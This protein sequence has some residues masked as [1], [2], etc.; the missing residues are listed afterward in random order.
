MLREHADLLSRSG[1]NGVVGTYVDSFYRVHD[2]YRYDM[3]KKRNKEAVAASK[4]AAAAVKTA[5]SGDA[6]ATKGGVGAGAGVGNAGGGR[7]TSESPLPLS[8]TS[9]DGSVL[10]KSAEYYASQL[11]PLIACIGLLSRAPGIENMLDVLVRPLISRVD[12]ALSPIDVIIIEEL[13]NIAT[14]CASSSYKEIVELYVDIYLRQTRAADS[15]VSATVTNAFLFLASYI[16]IEHAADL[17]KRLMRLFLL[18]GQRLDDSITPKAVAYSPVVK[19]MSSL[20][21]AI[22]KLMV[23]LREHD[24]MMQQLNAAQEMARG[25]GGAN[26]DMWNELGSDDERSGGSSMYDEDEAGSDGEAE[27]RRRHVSAR[28]A[29]RGG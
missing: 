19:C 11:R 3:R 21:P 6:G 2:S 29:S 27:Q 10:E 9:V 24:E 1:L 26:D 4:A 25:G 18:F 20:L 23:R 28:I 16:K 8:A 22:S 7:A 14:S 15:P 5:S 12:A 17:C 13:S